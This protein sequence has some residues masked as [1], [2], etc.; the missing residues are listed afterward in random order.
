MLA[1]PI[2]QTKTNLEG[3]E[4]V[5]RRVN[6]YWNLYAS[7]PD[8]ST[9][10]SNQN[11]ATRQELENQII[12]LYKHLLMYQ[13]KTVCSF[14]RHRGLV[15][16]RDTFKLDDWTGDLTAIKDAERRL[17][18]DTIISYV[19]QVV[20]H[21]LSEKDQ[22]CLRHLRLTD[23]RH[24]KMRI[25]QNE[26]GLLEVSYRWILQ[27][28][29]FKHLRDGRSRLLWITGDPGKG[30]TMLL[31]GIVNELQ[32]AEHGS[33]APGLLSFF[34]CQSN[35]KHLNNATAVVRGLL[36]L[37]VEQQ[38]CLLSHVLKWYDRAGQQ[39]FEGENAWVALSGILA[40]VLRDPAL[41]HACLIVDGLDECIDE[42]DR[43]NLLQFIVQ[44][45]SVSTRAKWIVSSRNWPQIEE[46]LE[47][48]PQKARLSLELNGA[49]VATAVDHYIRHKTSELSI[50]KQYD[51]DT[52]T[53]V[54]DYLSSHAE[55]TFLWVALV[56][57]NLESVSRRNAVN[58]LST[59]PPGLDDLYGRMMDQLNQTEDVELCQ[60]ILAIVSV[61]H[62]PFT[63][64][65]LLFFV[66]VLNRVT[67]S[68]EAYEEIVALCGSF[69][70]LRNDQVCFVHQ[71]AQDFLL[72]RASAITPPFTEQA[73]CH[74]TRDCLRLLNEAAK[75]PGGIF[76]YAA[77]NWG[78][79]A[80][81][82][83]RNAPSFAS[84]MEFL[85][86]KQKPPESYKVLLDQYARG[87]PPEGISGAHLAAHFGLRQCLTDL[88]AEGWNLD[89]KDENG[90]TPLLWAARNNQEDTVMW[91][92]HHGVDFEVR[93]FELK[94]ILHH[95]VL[96]RWERPLEFLLRK[97]AKI[98]ADIENMTPVHYAIHGWWEEGIDI[99]IN[100]EVSSINI[101]VHRLQYNQASRDGRRVYELRGSQHEPSRN[102]SRNQ[103]LTPLH[104]AAQKGLQEH[105]RFLL[106][107]GAD[108]GAISER[109]ET[110]L[111]LAVRRIL[112]D[113][114]F[115]LWNTPESRI[116]I[117]LDFI[118]FSDDKEYGDQ[119]EYI[120]TELSGLVEELL[121]HPASAVNAQT[122]DGSQALHLVR[123][124]H[125]SS[126]PLV[127]VLVKHGA[128]VSGRNDKQQ[129]PLL[130]ACAE[131]DAEVVLLLLNSGALVT[132]SDDQGCNA[133]HYA[134]MS[135]NNETV[136]LILDATGSREQRDL[137][138]SRDRDGQNALHHILSLPW[139]DGE[140]VLRLLEKGVDVNGMNKNGMTPLDIY[141]GQW[142]YHSKDVV[143]ALLRWG[144]DITTSGSRRGLGHELAH[145]DRLD[146]DILKLLA[147]AG[148]DLGAT[149]AEG[150]TVLHHSAQSG[151]LT[152]SALEYLVNV[153]G[154]SPDDVDSAGKR[155]LD[156]A[157]EMSSK[158]RNPHT[159]D[160]DRWRRT[161]EILT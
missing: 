60:H 43:R 34:F 100:A 114:S 101:G 61:V 124:C 2:K 39:L 65:E 81:Q 102:A 97:D 57:R 6:W 83:G 85:R 107:R 62:R 22:Q 13:M 131:G 17:L 28:P 67:D 15:F 32:E 53:A 40:D 66:G 145:S 14:Y 23:P 110:P 63:L 130:L 4:Y 10:N 76:E 30:K 136:S 74:A 59:F 156:Y 118:D 151:S 135:G 126:K 37:L 103:G 132:E 24:D 133:L 77:T 144:A 1:N 140:A 96:R 115:D 143:E 116:E 95:A 153:V 86:K 70:S 99:F 42:R 79:H 68:V 80:L 105:V 141:I 150:K 155:A 7:L 18:D 134:A 11:L 113:H 38:R 119:I 93:D 121:S 142:F 84:T 160:P 111:H 35:N 104:F 16:L 88:A 161:M 112:S 26:D 146:V 128:D 122:S 89:S 125:W 73:H 33:T 41:G 98:T 19:G 48:A 50:L 117:L 54:R 47:A 94:S 56:C 108:P 20:A 52:E 109:G 123:Y 45:S 159:F 3:I 51:A 69:L 120:R 49:S 154:L 78:F 71:S 5:A 8:E 92:L 31:C 46:Q 91:L 58:R 12:Y 75:A 72:S 29:E 127:S 138:L 148:L 106:A 157:T 64:Q 149:D 152:P 9:S 27:N 82:A 90:E 158:K 139:C 36:Y 129:T 87:R 137:V 147:G 21:Q 55:G 25:E 44:Q